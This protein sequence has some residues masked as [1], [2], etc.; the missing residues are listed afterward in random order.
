MYRDTLLFL[1]TGAAMIWAAL[2]FADIGVVGVLV[3]AFGLALG[4]FIARVLPERYIPRQTQVF[5]LIAFL[6]IV[7]PFRYFVSGFNPVYIPISISGNLYLLEKFFLGAFLGGAV[8]IVA[9]LICRLLMSIGSSKESPLL[10]LVLSLG[11]LALAAYFF[12]FVS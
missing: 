6:A 11:F 7:V 2:R 8:L 9:P 3:G 12:Q 5:G 1:A 10:D 4:I